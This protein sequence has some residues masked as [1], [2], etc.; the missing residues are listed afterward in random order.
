MLYNIYAAYRERLSDLVP[1][2]KNEIFSDNFSIHIYL[3]TSK[4]NYNFVNFRK[5]IK[6]WQEWSCVQKSGTFLTKSKN[7]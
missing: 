2:I 6:N 1:I 4:I 3:F 7:K 5:L